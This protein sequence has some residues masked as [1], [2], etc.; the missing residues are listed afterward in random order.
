MKKMNRSFVMSV[1]V[2]SVAMQATASVADEADGASDQEHRSFLSKVGG[3]I[4]SVAQRARIVST[5]DEDDYSKNKKGV[6][7]DYAK[8]GAQWVGEKSLDGVQA[9]GRFAKERVKKTW[10]WCPNGRK[11]GFLW[12]CKEED[13]YRKALKQLLRGDCPEKFGSYGGKQLSDALEHALKLGDD[14]WIERLQSDIREKSK[15][16]LELSLGN[17]RDIRQYPESMIEKD[18]RLKYGVKYLV[19]KSRAGKMYISMK[20]HV[21]E[22][23]D[24]GRVNELGGISKYR[25][26]R[27]EGSV[28]P[29]VSSQ[30]MSGGDESSGSGA[31]EIFAVE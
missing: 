22:V 5:K 25:P 15:G 24:E 30:M 7:P 20:R 29:A 8:D 4:K 14:E 28:K 9:V 1:L 18:E 6:F 10:D 13:V 17:T 23:T 26:F 16:E 11:L 3:G 2:L 27:C 21:P 12:V 19:L 31:G